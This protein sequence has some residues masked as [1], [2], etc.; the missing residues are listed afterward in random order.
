MGSMRYF[1]GEPAYNNVSTLQLTG[2]INVDTQA[3]LASANVE[4]LTMHRIVFVGNDSGELVD[5]ANLMWDTATFYVNGRAEIDNIEIDGNKI[6]TLGD[7]TTEEIPETIVNIVDA[8][9]SNPIV[10]TT[11]TNHGFRNGDIVSVD[12]IDT[13]SMVEISGRSFEVLAASGTTFSLKDENGTT[14]NSFTPVY[15][16]YFIEGPTLDAG[17]LANMPSQSRLTINGIDVTLTDPTNLRQIILD[18]G[19]D[20]VGIGAPST[21]ANIPGV[22]AKIWR[23]T[24]TTGTGTGDENTGLVLQV[25]KN[26][27]GSVTITEHPRDA[28]NDSLYNAGWTPKVLGFV[29]GVYNELGFTEL[30]DAVPSNPTQTVIST[31]N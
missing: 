16:F 2:D 27:A 28:R 5:D 13:A 26:L 14:Y 23:G 10:V 18:I 6:T 24:E 17:R 20:D 3:T 25:D 9:N 15:D 29:P 22:R 1:V 21:G 30:A 8:T 19:T 31:N 12:G 11:S 4:D 7:C